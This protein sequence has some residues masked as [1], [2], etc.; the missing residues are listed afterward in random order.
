M[1]FFVTKEEKDAGK[2]PIIVSILGSGADSNFLKRGDRLLDGY[3]VL[4]EVFK[5][6]ARI[7]IVEKPGVEIGQ[8]PKKIGSSEGSSEEFRRASASPLYSQSLYRA[9][10]Y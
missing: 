7:L 2:P 1:R 10:I 5:G 8:H 3:R 6:K 9:A 4:R